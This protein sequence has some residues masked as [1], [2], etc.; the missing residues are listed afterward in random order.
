MTKK[1]I[2]VAWF[3]IC[4]LLS[5]I[6]LLGTFN[7]QEVMANI[8]TFKAIDNSYTQEDLTNLKDKQRVLPKKIESLNSELNKTL[9]PIPINEISSER[10]LRDV[11]ELSGSNVKILKFYEDLSVPKKKTFHISLEGSNQQLMKTMYA[12]TNRY[13]NAYIKM[14]SI[15]LGI[16]YYDSERTYDS[17]SKLEWFNGVINQNKELIPIEEIET[18]ILNK[19]QE[20]E[21]RKPNA[22]QISKE[23]EIKELNRMI[24]NSIQYY[25]FSI[26]RDRDTLSKF[27]GSEQSNLE[28]EANTKISQLEE[29]RSKKL[30]ELDE[31]WKE[32]ETSSEW[33][34]SDSEFMK[35]ISFVDLKSLPYKS[36]LVITFDTEKF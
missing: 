1:Q 26:E 7:I 16:G 30:Q 29:L 10:I 31:K 9:S 5:S 8:Q 12:F 23:N 15:R 35:E 28:S 36:D 14:L 27:E 11:V 25:Q 21:A 18:K 34:K 2:L 3:S 4:S 32:I 24:D 33:A 17:K 22:L 13:K 20:K 6:L 19:N